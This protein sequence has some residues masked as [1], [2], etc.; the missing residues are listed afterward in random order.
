MP[1]GVT[2]RASPTSSHPRRPQQPTTYR[3]AAGLVYP[4]FDARGGLKVLPKLELSPLSILEGYNGIGKSAAVRLLR[5]CVGEN[6]Y[7]GEHSLW[8]SFKEGLGPTTVTA[9][10]VGCDPVV[11]RIDHQFLLLRMVGMTW[12]TSRSPPSSGTAMISSSRPRSSAAT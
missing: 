8:E 9:T 2:P 11:L 5:I 1:P 3:L 12:M 6:P 7:P 4:Q 10:G